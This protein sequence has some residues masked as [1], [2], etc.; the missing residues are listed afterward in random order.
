MF[1]FP[2]TPTAGQTVTGPN[3]QIYAWDATAG[4]WRPA[5]SSLALAPINSPHFT[6][7]PT[8]PTGPYGDATTQVASDA[9]VQQAVAPALNNVGR[10][11]IHNAMFNIQQR[12]AGPWTTNLGYTADRWQLAFAGDT[13]TASLVA[14]SDGGRAAVGDENAQW[15][16]NL[17]FT[18]SAAANSY[19]SI[20]QKVENVRRL[21]GKSVTVSF[22]AAATGNPRIAVNVVQFFGTGGSPSASVGTPIGVTAAVSAT[23]TRYQVTAALPSS[24][25]K[26]FGTNGNDYSQLGFF[27]SDQANVSG[28]GI[29][30]QSGTVQIWGVQ[31]E[32]AQPGQTQ[33]TPLEKLDPVLQLQQCQR[34]F[35]ATQAGIGGYGVAGVVSPSGSYVQLPVTMRAAPTAAI[36][37]P[38]YGNASALGINTNTTFYTT[39][40]TITTTGNFYA[41]ATVQFSADL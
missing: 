17:N 35:Y 41:A 10:N 21:A 33:P 18:G 3:G 22:W 19:S 39:G 28:G 1:D 24:S 31:L 25:G 29:G 36:L 15:Q 4:V 38:A 12:G 5:A 40:C 2:N 26:T 13:D 34:F 27:L 37:G 14:F 30:V 11:L 32:V 20:L 6:G 8:T 9:F 23:W 7:V 16:L